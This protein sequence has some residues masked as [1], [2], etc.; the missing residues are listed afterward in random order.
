MF[1]AKSAMS[2][3]RFGGPERNKSLA[4][5]FRSGPPNRAGGLLSREPYRHVTPNGV[6]TDF[7]AYR[8]RIL[9]L[10]NH[11]SSP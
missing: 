8:L 3:A 4:T 1:I 7:L 2:R 10:R 9:I 11:T 5:R 6:K